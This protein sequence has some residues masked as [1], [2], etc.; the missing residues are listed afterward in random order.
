MNVRLLPALMAT[1]GVVLALK[2]VNVAEAASAP[3]PLDAS[4]A[5]V[6]AAAPAPKPATGASCPPPNFADQAGLSATEV[7]VLQSLGQRRAQLDARAADI[8]T[9]GALLGATEKSVND[10]IAELKRVEAAV[11][12]LMAKVDDSQNEQVE[13]MVNVY[14]K[15]KPKD[16]ARIFDALDDDVLVPVA[17]KMKQG[18]LAEIM[19]LMNAD[20]ARKITKMLMMKD[21]LPP[22]ILAIAPAA[23]AP[24]APV[25]PIA[26]AP[27]A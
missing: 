6:A 1:A 27:P 5:P 17:A 12:A 26:P 22:D 10:R 8:D 15:M 18:N 11:S 19:G 14:T 16:A 3:A 21:R 2:A 24:A 7:D 9:Q 25:A 13:A 20:R 4:A 23:A